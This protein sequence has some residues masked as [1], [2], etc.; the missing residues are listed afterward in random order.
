MPFI[1]T[2]VVYPIKSLD[3]ARACWEDCLFNASGTVVDFEIGS[4]HLNGIKPCQHCVVPSRDPFT[5]ETLT[6]FQI[7]FARKCRETPPDWAESSRFDHYYCLSVNTRIPLTEAGKIIRAGDEIRL[8]GAHR[9]VSQRTYTENDS[10][11]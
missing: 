5:G 9:R 11:R 1:E 4:V 2:L 6:G 3:G 8:L 7:A 10:A